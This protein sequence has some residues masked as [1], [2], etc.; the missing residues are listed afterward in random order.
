MS[1]FMFGSFTFQAPLLGL[2]AQRNTV[3]AQKVGGAQMKKDRK[4]GRG[5][6]RPKSQVRIVEFAAAVC[7]HAPFVR[8]FGYDEK[9]SAL[10]V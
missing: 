3:R 2:F 5:V 1:T 9:P 8:A 10:A 7:I 4:V 6:T